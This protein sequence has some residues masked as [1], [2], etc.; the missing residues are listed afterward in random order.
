M[1]ITTS[2]LPT[3]HGGVRSTQRNVSENGLKSVF[4]R[5]LTKL[6]VSQFSFIQQNI[7]APPIHWVNLYC[8]MFY[9]TTSCQGK[10]KEIPK[11]GIVYKSQ[12]HTKELL[13]VSLS[14]MIW[15]TYKYL[16]MCFDSGWKTQTKESF[17]VLNRSSECS[18]CYFNA[19]LSN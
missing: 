18:C 3:S 17:K 16:Y 9:D 8:H 19:L 12:P 1:G 11:F 15:R 14:P 10:T 7:S 2:V 5:I 6:L 4:E 13:L